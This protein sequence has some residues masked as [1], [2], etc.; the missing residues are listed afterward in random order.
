MVATPSPASGTTTALAGR[1]E[2]LAWNLPDKA[3]RVAANVAKLPELVPRRSEKLSGA[4]AKQIE[5]QF[6]A[7]FGIQLLTLGF[8][9]RGFMRELTKAKHALS[10]RN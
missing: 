8:N 2:V 5:P 9:V 7:L 4:A 6:F 1:G 3:R 10:M